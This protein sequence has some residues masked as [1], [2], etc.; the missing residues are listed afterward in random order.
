MSC[1]L[2]KAHPLGLTNVYIGNHGPIAT[3]TA[4]TVLAQS[5]LA[6]LVYCVYDIFYFTVIRI[7]HSPY[8]KRYDSANLLTPLLGGLCAEQC[9]DNTVGCN[10]RRL[11]VR[12][13]G[14]MQLGAPIH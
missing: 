10:I 2:A 8:R 13:G 5:R 12:G 11:H 6:V 9:A 4:S 14:I 7:Q 3:D 1:N